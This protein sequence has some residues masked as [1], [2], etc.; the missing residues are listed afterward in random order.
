[1]D[2]FKEVHWNL[3]QVAAWVCLRDAE[4]VGL[5]SDSCEEEP[6]PAQVTIMAMLR[7]GEESTAWS[8]A[9]NQIIVALQRGEIHAS[10]VCIG[11][12]KRAEIDVL[13][14]LSLRFEFDP[15]QG[16]VANAQGTCGAGWEKLKFNSTEIV[17]KWPEFNAESAAA[18]PPDITDRELRAWIKHDAWTAGQAML[19]LHG[20][21][22]RIQWLRNGELTTHFSNAKTYLVC[23]PAKKF[24]KSGEFFQD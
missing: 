9:R 15:D 20:K 8:E 4:L 3:T 5:H 12:A 17:A 19:L 6:L 24:R 2:A 11:T 18:P 16:T 14:W 1:M 13:E 22:P 10:G 21:T 23:C 7:S